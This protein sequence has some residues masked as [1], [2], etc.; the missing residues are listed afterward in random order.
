[1]GNNCVYLEQ[2]LTALSVPPNVR[3]EIDD[4][5]EEWTYSEPF[6][7]IHSRFMNFSIQNWKNYLTKIYE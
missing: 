4:I 3:F 1:M 7:F 6:D 5:D 2:S